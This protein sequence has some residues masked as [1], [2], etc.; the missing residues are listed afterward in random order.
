VN[1]ADGPS[2]VSSRWCD[3]PADM[4]VK[5]LIWPY[6]CTRYACHTQAVVRGSEDG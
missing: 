2:S 4:D 5:M 3:M 1:A 6:V